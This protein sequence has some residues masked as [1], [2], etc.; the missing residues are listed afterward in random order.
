MRGTKAPPSPQALDK[1]TLSSA[2][3]H[4]VGFS[5]VGI[6]SICRQ[7]ITDSNA[8]DEQ[9]RDLPRKG[10]G[11][12]HQ[13]FWRIPKMDSIGS[14]FCVLHRPVFIATAQ[15][16]RRTERILIALDFEEGTGIVAVMSGLLVGRHVPAEVGLRVELTDRNGG[17]GTIAAVSEHACV[18]GCFLF[19]SLGETSMFSPNCDIHLFRVQFTVLCPAKIQA[20]ALSN[21]RFFFS[22]LL[23][24]IMQVLLLR[25]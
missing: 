14:S 11:E 16:R 18:K 4:G 7:R 12:H 3:W 22:L 15:V 19:K 9:D 2:F 25:V 17:Q 13:D 6:S 21:P 20:S 5:K 1:R 24:Q 8:H 10:V 23:K